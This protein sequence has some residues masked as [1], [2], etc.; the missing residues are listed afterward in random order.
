MQVDL[1]PFI[2]WSHHPRQI[3]APRDRIITGGDPTDM[4]FL[5]EQGLALAPKAA[6]RNQLQPID[7]AKIAGDVDITYKAGALISL[8]EMLSLETYR[9]DVFANEECRVIGINRQEIKTMWDR[10]SH[11]AWPLS[12]SIASTITQRRKTR[13]LI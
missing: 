1:L 12:R 13:F 5:L 10:D 3:V 6:L 2:D 9:H 4:L 7:T 11:L 8:L